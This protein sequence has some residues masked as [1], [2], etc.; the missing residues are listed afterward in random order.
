MNTLGRTLL[1][2]GIIPDLRHVGS[3]NQHVRSFTPSTARSSLKSPIGSPRRLGA[4]VFP[5]A[6]KLDIAPA[7]TQSCEVQASHTF[8]TSRTRLLARLKGRRSI[9][10]Q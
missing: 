9:P 7:R 8:S 6:C 3:I 4:R 10:P 2:A 1:A 5:V